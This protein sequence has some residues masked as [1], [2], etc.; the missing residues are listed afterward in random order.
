M[1]TSDSRRPLRAKTAGAI[2]FICRTGGDVLPW[3][4]LLYV[5]NVAYAMNLF[6]ILTPIYFGR[7]WQLPSI[8]TFRSKF[9]QR[10]PDC[11]PYLD[12][13]GG[14]PAIA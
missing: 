12:L 14:G 9:S 7:C 8:S 13:H 11:R 10:T 6:L 3:S 2:H 1:A 5:K 4:Q